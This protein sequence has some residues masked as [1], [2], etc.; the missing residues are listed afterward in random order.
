[1]SI[2]INEE[3]DVDITIKIKVEVE[4]R[5]HTASKLWQNVL[6][7]GIFNAIPCLAICLTAYLTVGL[8]SLPRFCRRASVPL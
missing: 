1:M 8:S 7:I 5:L 3:L 2:I 4:V 6:I